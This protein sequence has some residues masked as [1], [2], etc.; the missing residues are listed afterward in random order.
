MP[1]KAGVFGR[2]V[3]RRRQLAAVGFVSLMVSSVQAKKEWAF[4]SAFTRA[5]TSARVL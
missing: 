4:A 3:R 2:G 1:S 5:S